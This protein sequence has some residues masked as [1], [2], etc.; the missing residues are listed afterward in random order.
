MREQAQREEDAKE[1]LEAEAHSKKMAKDAKDRERR[2]L[3]EAEDSKTRSTAPP[4]GFPSCPTD[5]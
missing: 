5:P 3:Q 2:R 4:P 1:K